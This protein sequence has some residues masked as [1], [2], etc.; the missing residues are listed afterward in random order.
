MKQLSV[1]HL[2]NP[3]LNGSS[4]IAIVETMVSLGGY[5]NSKAFLGRDKVLDRTLTPGSST[6]QFFLMHGYGTHNIL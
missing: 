1:I 3:K 5:F 4:I 6:V 2:E